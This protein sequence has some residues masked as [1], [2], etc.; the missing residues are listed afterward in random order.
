VRKLYYASGFVVLS[1]S[2]CDAVLDYAHG[3]AQAR[4]SA[5]VTVPALSD[6]GARGRTTLLI[7]PSSE[8]FAAPAL[9]R[10]V[11]LDDDD[12]VALMRSEIARLLPPRAMGNDRSESRQDS[13]FDF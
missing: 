6:E 7:G 9:D 4:Q 12:T 10:G 1:D 2:V 5:L 8:L 13:A 3:L 11:N